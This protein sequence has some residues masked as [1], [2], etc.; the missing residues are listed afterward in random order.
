MFWSL[1]SFIH[2]CFIIEMCV[3]RLTTNV[4]Y[5]LGQIFVDKFTSL[6]KIDFTIECF[7]LAF[8]NLFLPKK[9]KILLLSCV[10]SIKSKHFRD[11]LAFFSFTKILSLNLFSN[12]WGTWCIHLIVIIIYNPGH[13][14]LA[15]FNNLAQVRIA[16]SKT[17]LDI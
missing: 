6:S 1:S 15:L 4:S 5:T 3:F 7:T 12:S 17:M 13:N 11:V 9:V 2:I 10:F 14:I 16:T 8:F